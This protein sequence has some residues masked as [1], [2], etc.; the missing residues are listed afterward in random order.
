MLA[1][2]SGMAIDIG[3][4]HVVQE[5]R[6]DAPA[7]L[8]I[9]NAAA[10]I[11]LWE[12]VVPALAAAYR[13]IRVDLLDRGRSGSAAG[14]DVLA[15]ARRAAG[16]LDSLGVERVTAVGHSSGGY[17]ATALAGQHPG[18]VAALALVNTGPSTDAEV[19]EPPLARIL[20]VPLAGQ[21][22]WRLKTAGAIRKSA[23]TAF[24][25]PVEIPGAFVT[26]VMGMTYQSFTG[27]MRGY[28]R[29]LSQRDVPGRLT[30][31]GLPV[32]VIFG[33]D[34]KRW[35]SALAAGYRDVPGARVEMLPGVGHTPMIEDP[36]TTARL[37]LDFASAPHDR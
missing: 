17:V 37:L 28:L 34:D 35:R 24:T 20:N 10:P 36:Q 16:V 6:L 22:L 3:G 9:Q 1:G 23:S 25:R 15:Q 19:P 21:L 33:T 11:E 13:V 8:L 26:H 12:P 30:A 7:L 14:H 31:L 5:G 4:I 27:T 2:M 32:L 29:Y 18:K